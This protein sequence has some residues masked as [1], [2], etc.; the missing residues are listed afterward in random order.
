MFD[1]EKGAFF[2]HA[3]LIHSIVKE[4]SESYS[5]YIHEAIDYMYIV[6]KLK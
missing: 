6:E 3:I 1:L 5:P 2:E 4:I